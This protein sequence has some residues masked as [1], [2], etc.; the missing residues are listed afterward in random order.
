[1]RLNPDNQPPK[2]ALSEGE[3]R[4]YQ[5]LVQSTKAAKLDDRQLVLE[6]MKQVGDRFAMGSLADAL[7]MELITRFERAKGIEEVEELSPDEI[8]YRREEDDGLHQ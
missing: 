7:L 5:F 1:M 6:V 3:A 8:Q 2:A 4:L